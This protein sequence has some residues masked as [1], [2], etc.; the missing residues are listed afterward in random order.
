MLPI[1]GCNIVSLVGP[2]TFED[3]NASN[4]VR[5]KVSSSNWDLLIAT[6]VIVGILPPTRHRPIAVT[7]RYSKPEKRKRPHIE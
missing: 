1:N 2:F 4:R 5:Q 6:C 7:P 3:I